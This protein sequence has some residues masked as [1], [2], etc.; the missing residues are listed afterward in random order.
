[1]TDTP[2]NLEKKGN[3]PKGFIGAVANEVAKI[4]M[5]RMPRFPSRPQKKQV[6]K[7]K[8]TE[9]EHGTFL[10]TSAII[11]GR[12]FDIIELQLL[13]G[14]LVIP[15]FILSELKHIADSQDM[16][17]RERGQRGLARLEIVRK[18]KYMKFVLLSDD[19]ISPKREIEVDDRLIMI[20]KKYKG[21]VITCDF[22][23]EKKATV[24]GVTAINVHEIANRLK[25]LAVPGE[26][27]HMTIQH[28]GKDPTQ[29][30]GYLEDGTMV[31]VER[32]SADVGMETDVVITRVIQTSSGRILFAKKL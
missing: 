16:V 18:K 23:L 2:Q 14:S 26:A 15:D 19:V 28:V 21:R 5:E 25:V 8:N 10:D 32:A 6:K 29:G 30:V 7:K 3:L 27:L 22:N 4:M 13:H 9:A 11:D 17:K 24:S 20:T 31:V 1:M 12:I